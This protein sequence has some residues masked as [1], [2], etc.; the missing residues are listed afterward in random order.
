MK[1]TIAVMGLVIA[2]ASVHA[3]NI[4]TKQIYFGAGISSNDIS[5]ANSAVGFQVFGGIPLNVNLG[6]VQTALEVGYMNSGNFDVNTPFG[7]YSTNA[8]GIW[9]TAVATLPLQNNLDLVGRLG[10]DFGDDNGMMIGAG[11]GVPV[12]NNMKV[13]FEYVIRD[14]ID[15]L[16]ANLVIYQ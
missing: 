14:H 5:Y 8:T 15:S 10:Y 3:Q 7:T 12:A 16:Q 1:K 9:S 11:L 13:R 6:N 2:S 4:N